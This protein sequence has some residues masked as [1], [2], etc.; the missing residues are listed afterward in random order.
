MNEIK[1]FLKRRMIIYI[2]GA[3]GAG[4]STVLKTLPIPGYDLD[5]L[6]EAGWKHHRKFELVQ[7]SVKQEVAKLVAAHPHIAFVGLQGSDQ[8]PFAPDHVILLVRTDY[9]MYYRQKLVRDL[10]LLCENQKM[11]EETFMKEPLDT[12]KRFYF[13]SNSVVGMTSLEEFKTSVEKMNASIQKDFPD[14][15]ALEFKKIPAFI[16]KLIK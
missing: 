11:Y 2:T 5:D 1:L 6:Y 16:R 7:K 15:V 4:K 10:R 8:V 12:M 14:A 13:W 3:S 9:E